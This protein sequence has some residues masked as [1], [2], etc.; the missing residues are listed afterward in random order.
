MNYIKEVFEVQTFEHAKHVVLTS[1]PNNPNKFKQETEF[2]V[3]KILEKNFIKPGSKVL[4]FGC[5]MGRVSKEILNRVDCQVIGVDRSQSMR[6]FAMLYVSE[7]KKFQP[8][9]EYITPESIDVCLS[10]LVLQ[11]TQDP[12]KEIQ[13]IYNVLKPGGIFILLNEKKRLVPAEIDKNNF[14]VWKDDK[15]DIFE[16]VTFNNFKIIGK[17]KYLNS[18]SEIIFYTKL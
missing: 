7:P 17:Q 9:E 16:L 1:D 13:N 4:D 18:D 14:I 8:L 6:M 2:L 11:H 3:D 12:K 5:G 15:I 10:I